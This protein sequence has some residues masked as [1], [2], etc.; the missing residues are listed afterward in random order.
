MYDTYKIRRTD[1]PTMGGHIGVLYRQDDPKKPKIGTPNT[2]I[3]T[4]SNTIL[5]SHSPQG[6]S[7]AYWCPVQKS[8]ASLLKSYSNLG[9]HPTQIF[10]VWN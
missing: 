4:P 5:P 2:R 10:L 6:R 3:F 9:Y 7:L 1:I 8:G